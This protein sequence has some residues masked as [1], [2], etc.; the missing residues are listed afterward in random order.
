MAA[1]V[2]AKSLLVGA[3]TI[4]ALSVCIIATG[5]ICVQRSRDGGLLLLQ[6]ISHKLSLKPVTRVPEVVLRPAQCFW[7]MRKED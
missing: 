1:L 6:Q 4:T 3:A 5:V 7:Y 2:T